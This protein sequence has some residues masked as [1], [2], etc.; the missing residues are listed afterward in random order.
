MITPYKIP[1]YFTL[2]DNTLKQNTNCKNTGSISR[3]TYDF[4]NP[5]AGWLKS[6]CE[7]VDTEKYD[8]VPKKDYQIKQLKIKVEKNQNSIEQLKREIDIKQSFI[9]ICEDEIKQAEEELSRLEK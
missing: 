2:V 5:K 8:I 4:S 7:L 6:T 3:Y 9:K 1:D